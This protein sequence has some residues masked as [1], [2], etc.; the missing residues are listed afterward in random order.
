MPKPPGRSKLDAPSRVTWEVP[1][2]LTP[3]EGRRLV[4]QVAAFG[5]PFP[6]LVLAGNDP[7]ARA[8]L[9]ELLALARGHGLSP[10]LSTLGRPE[11]TLAVRERIRASGA[12]TVAL[13]LEGSSPTSHDAFHRLPG[14]FESTRDL[15]ARARDLG[16]RMQLGTLV[17]P[18]NLGELGRILQHV[19]SLGVRS[20]HVAFPGGLA[21]AASE[22][23]VVLHFLARA[24]QS[25]GVSTTEA[26]HLQRVQRQRAD[27]W[28]A[29]IC[30]E[31]GL[32]IAGQRLGEHPLYRKLAD[33]LPPEVPRVARKPRP[34]TAA[35][36]SN[37]VFVDAQGEVRPCAWLGLSAG[38]VRNQDLTAIYRG[39]RLFGPL[40]DPA[41]LTG[42]CA[43]CEF[44]ELCA[45][46]WARSYA[47]TGSTQG[48]DPL[49]A[50]EPGSGVRGRPGRAYQRRGG[51]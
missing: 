33:Y 19:V 8:D 21:V 23:E 48:E 36:G 14:S 42:R 49:C 22:C 41:R 5:Y 18:T 30:P 29:G 31:D 3:R 32:L 7:F 39:S 6:A 2:A 26:H 40:R 12:H 11:F 50:Y 44:R 43:G 15:C 1:G 16:L 51:A 46:S 20:W 24:G 38:N 17:D 9:F 37:A 35:A 4:E 28:A 34:I 27:S 47:D 10:V 13:S 25:L 45:G